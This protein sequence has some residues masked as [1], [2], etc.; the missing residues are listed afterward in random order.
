MQDNKHPASSEIEQISALLRE[1]IQF[2]LHEEGDYPLAIPG[3]TLHRRHQTNEPENCFYKPI[4]GLT[5]QGEKR[6]VIGNQEYR[7]R[8]N[9]CI[10]TGVDM[11][12]IN[13]ITDA[14]PEKP[15]L[16]FRC[17]WIFS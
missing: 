9:N 8:A 3:V 10:V 5:L 2:Y 11:P 1:K 13:Y 16:S 14:S 15:Y 4:L 17:I 12:S 6:T 7:Y